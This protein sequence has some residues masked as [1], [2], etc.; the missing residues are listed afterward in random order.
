MKLELLNKKK[1]KKREEETVI[2]H[3]PLPLRF[4]C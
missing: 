3:G 4:D 2:E 1:Q